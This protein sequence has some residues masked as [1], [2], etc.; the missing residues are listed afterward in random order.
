M[1]KTIFLTLI[2]LLL[3]VS[4]G[5]R[6][7]VVQKAEKSYFKFVGNWQNAV[8]E[9]DNVKP[10]KLDDFVTQKGEDGTEKVSSPDQKLYQTLPGKQIGRAHV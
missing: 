8:V 9:I 4:C 6:E 3:L 10:F 1:K 5:Y 7:G 2:P